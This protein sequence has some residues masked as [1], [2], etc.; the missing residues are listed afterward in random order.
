MSNL[1]QNC[2]PVD[3]RIAGYMNVERGERER[4]KKI[5]SRLIVENN[6]NKKHWIKMYHEA[7][8]AIGLYQQV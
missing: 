2:E 7:A 3:Y 4:D 8:R 5:T 1:I 6:N